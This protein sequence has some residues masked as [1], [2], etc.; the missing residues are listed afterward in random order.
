MQIIYSLTNHCPFKCGICSMNAGPSREPFHPQAREICRNVADLT[1]LYPD[2]EFDLSGGDP[3]A[4]EVLPLTLDAL[5][6]LG[7]QRCSVSTTGFTLTS[8]MLQ[9][10]PRVQGFDFTVEIGPDFAPRDRRPTGYHRSTRRGLELCAKQGFRVSAFTVLTHDTAT[11]DNLRNIQTFLENNGVNH[12]VWLPLFRVGRAAL[13]HRRLWEYPAP[14]ELRDSLH[15]G[16]VQPKLQH[17]LSGEGHC[18][19]GKEV[20][21]VSPDGLLATCPWALDAQGAPRKDFLLGDL[22]RS[23]IASLLKREL[24]KGTC[25]AE[26]DF[27]GRSFAFAPLSLT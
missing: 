20:L 2:V 13:K 5:D 27:P 12:W 18:H 7:P 21:Y 1:H 15:P 23:P 17:T 25:P 26:Y 6:I 16:K 9:D 10:F 22:T 19:A 14:E 24:P 11:A 3:L 8:A 4:P